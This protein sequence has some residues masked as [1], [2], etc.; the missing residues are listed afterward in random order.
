MQRKSRW[1]ST[2]GRIEISLVSQSEQTVAIG[3]DTFDFAFGEEICTEHCHKYDL[4]EFADRATR[5][6]FEL[7]QHWTDEQDYFAVLFLSAA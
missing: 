6:G 4:H 2:P 5:A 3:E 7:T 1:T